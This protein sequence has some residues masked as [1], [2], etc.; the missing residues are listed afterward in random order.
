MLGT[1]GS[2]DWIENFRMKKETF[3]YLCD[4][5]QPAIFRRNTRFRK[6]IGVEKRVAITLWCLATPCEY[7]TVAHL[8]V[9][10]YVK[11]RHIEI[12]R[13]YDYTRF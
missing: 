10:A 9:T 12:T 11:T 3:Y 1:F 5:S 8:F 4:K 2:R 7:R 6:A 13:N